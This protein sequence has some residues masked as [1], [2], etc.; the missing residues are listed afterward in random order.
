MSPIATFLERAARRFATAQ[1]DRLKSQ[2]VS[3]IG[4]G[5][6]YYTNGDPPKVYVHFDTRP[7]H[8]PDGEWTHEFWETLLRTKWQAFLDAHEA[9]D[10]RG[11]VIDH[12]GKTHELKRLK[13]D[14]MALLVGKM[15]VEALKQTRK[16][17]VFSK[18][19]RSDNCE[20]GVE[21]ID[22]TF[23]W[24]AYAKRGAENRV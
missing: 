21:D 12:T 11:A 8:E 9:S 10:F 20:M 3:G 4:L 16:R 24:P 23:G 7:D 1:R 14:P 22:G 15:L 13:G 5:Y 17:G 6:V 18:L 2:R 19:R